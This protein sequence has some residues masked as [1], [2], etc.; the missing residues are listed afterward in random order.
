MGSESPFVRKCVTHY[1]FAAR[2]WGAS[3]KSPFAVGELGRDRF[4]TWK[5]R[6]AAAPPNLGAPQA[7]FVCV[8]ALAKLLADELGGYRVQRRLSL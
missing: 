8:R 3:R 5:K 7:P 1:T 2:P 4:A 6:D